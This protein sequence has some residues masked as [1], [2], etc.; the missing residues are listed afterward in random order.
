[1]T[2]AYRGLV[3]QAWLVCNR[4]A[5]DGRNRVPTSAGVALGGT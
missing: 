3:A 2:R 1:M 4:Q 5:L